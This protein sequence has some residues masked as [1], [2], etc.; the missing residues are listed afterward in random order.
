MGFFDLKGDLE[1][2]LILARVEKEICFVRSSN[3]AFHP[4]QSADIFIGGERCG[5]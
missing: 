4:G 2:L 5:T 1:S 3:L